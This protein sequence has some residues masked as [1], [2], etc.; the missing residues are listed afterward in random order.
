MPHFFG[1]VFYWKYDKATLIKNNLL[2]ITLVEHLWWLIATP[3][4]VN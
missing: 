2:V 3:K 1:S 4:S